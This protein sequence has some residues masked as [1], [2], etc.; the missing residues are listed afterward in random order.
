MLVVEC[1][2]TLYSLH[3]LLHRYSTR[4]KEYREFTP[5]MTSTSKEFREFTPE[6]TSTSKE[7]REFTPD[8]ASARSQGIRGSSLWPW[9]L[10]FMNKE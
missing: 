10:Q 4:I 2:C 7:F 1:M 5:D 3:Q 8:M 6:M 9:P